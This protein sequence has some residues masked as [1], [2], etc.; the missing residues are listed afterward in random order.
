MRWLLS[1]LMSVTC[2]A[3]CRAQDV[4]LATAKAKSAL[5]LI[6]LN[7]EAWPASDAKVKAAARFKKRQEDREVDCLS[8]L[9]EAL[10]RADAEKKSLF[11]LVGMGCHDAPDIRKDFPGAVWVHVG[12]SFNGNSTPR[13]LVRPVGSPTGIPFFRKDLG[14]G[15]P[16]EIREMLHQA[17]GRVSAESDGQI[18]PIIPRRGR[19]SDC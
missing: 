6:K 17:P 2:A 18:W 7:R 19:N 10:K 14:P 13:L 8:D 16:A 15:T 5:A 12:N 11:I 9:G 4:D 1:V 3:E